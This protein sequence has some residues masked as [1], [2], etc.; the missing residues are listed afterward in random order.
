[1]PMLIAP[2]PVTTVAVAGG[3]EFPVRRIY[4]V[5][6]N[7]AAHAREMG[8]D[9]NREPPFF[10]MKPADAIVP[11]ESVVPYPTMTQSYHHEIELVVALGGGGRDVPAER[12]LDLV[13]GYG[14]GLDMTRRDLQ[15]EAKA[16]RRPWDM[17]KGFDQSAPCA[18]LSPV[19]EIGHISS[20][21]IRLNVNGE[22]RQKGDISD[23]IWSVEDTI[24]F[25]SGLVELAPGDLIYTG[26]PDGVGAVVTG[27]RLHG[28][29]DGLTDLRITIG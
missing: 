8:A 21:A 24:A 26:T 2:S 18:P 29:I 1:M 13:F 5:G 19:S 15:D 7:Y 20:G 6:S 4:C 23:L 22:T 17:S 11:S 3:G 16:M 25:L 9:P 27:D 10:F 28:H 12:A 14:V